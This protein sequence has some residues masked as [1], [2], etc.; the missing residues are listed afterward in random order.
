M[1]TA[2]AADRY[3]SCSYETAHL[4]NIYNLQLKQTS[5]LSNNTKTMSECIKKRGKCDAFR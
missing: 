3:R 5:G 2:A 1:E 4:S